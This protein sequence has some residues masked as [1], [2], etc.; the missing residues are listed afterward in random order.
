MV[1]EKFPNQDS[2]PWDK[3]KEVRV[4]K[5]GETFSFEFD[6]YGR[7]R[8]MT[9]AIGPNTSSYTLSK[10]DGT[11]I[12][13]ADQKGTEISVIDFAASPTKLPGWVKGLQKKPKHS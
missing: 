11:P 13:H 8:K 6:I 3:I 10:E 2:I 7:K 12:L 1:S 5:D 4:S 9:I